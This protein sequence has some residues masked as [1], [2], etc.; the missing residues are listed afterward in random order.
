MV[1]EIYNKV[2]YASPMIPN[3]RHVSSCFC[4]L[5]KLFTMPIT[6]R[7][8]NEMLTHKDSPFI[9]VMG[10]LYARYVIDPKEMW[11]LLEPH[12]SDKTE[13]DPGANGQKR[14][15][16]KYVKGLIEDLNYFDTVLPRIP[17]LIQVPPPSLFQ[18]FPSS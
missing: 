18:L 15:L 9:K 12:L 6:T 1:D 13:V 10:L 14:T 8:L 4:I 11:G 5:H 16:G 2:T 17:V 7:Q 3:T